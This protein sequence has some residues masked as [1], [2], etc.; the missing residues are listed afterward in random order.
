MAIDNV[1]IEDYPPLTNGPGG[2]TA[3]LKLWLKAND[4]LAY[5]NGQSVS[6]WSDKGNGADAT[7][8]TSGQEPTYRDDKNYNVNFNPVVDFDNNYSSVSLD[9]DYSFDNT[10]TQFLEGTGGMY[11]QDIFL[12]LIP[13]TT[14]NSSF[15]SMDVF[16]GDELPG[17]N[18]TDATGIGLGAYSVR[19]SSEIICY[20]VGTTSSGNGY[21]VAEIGTGNTYN[22]AGII[23]SRNNLTASQQELYYNAL[24]IET[25]QNDIPDFSNVNNSRYWIGR[26]EGW[27][28]STDARIAEIITYSARKGDASLTDERNKI[29][30][31]LGIKYG[32]TLGSNGTSQDY[33]DSTGA[34]IWDQ[35]DN[36]G[37][38]YDI[39]G[40][41]RDDASELIQK[42]SKSVNSDFDG[43][44]QIRG[45]VS[46]GLTN[47]Y[48]T[49]NEN[50]ANNPITLN[51]REFLTWGNNNGNLDNAPNVVN[52][53][54]STGIT[55]LSTPVNFTGMERVWRVTE[56]N[57]NIPMVK[58][59]IPQSAIRNISPP[60]SYLMFISDTNIFD[61]TADY[62]VMT[63]NGAN[64]ET[65]YDFDGTKYITFGYAPEIAVERSVY[66]DGVN[67]YIDMEDVLD[68]NDSDFTISAWI[69]R[70]ASS[71]NTSILS[72]RDITY[73][74]GYDFKVTSAGLIEFSWKNGGSQ[75]V[76]SDFVVPQ[77]EWHQVAVIFN[78]GTANLYIDGILDKTAGSLNNPLDTDHSFFIAAAGKTAPTALFEGNI[79]E[80]RIWDVALTVD[81]LHYVMNQE[82]EKNTTFVNGSVLHKNLTKNEVAT[83]PWSNLAGYYPMSIYTYTNTND[84]SDNDNQGALRNLDTVDYQT[85]PLPYQSE[86]NGSWDTDATWL[87]NS[88]QYLP[89][90]TVNGT[91]V[92][93]NIVETFHNINSTR[94]I[95]VLGLKNQSNEISVK[96]DNKLEIT[97]YLKLDGIIDLEN[98]SQLIQSSNCELDVDSSGYIERDQ[99]GEGN[100]YRYNDWSSPVILQGTGNISSNGVGPN[101][102]TPF[103][104][105]D[106][107]RDGTDPSNPAE[108][109]FV[110]GYN[111]A[112]GPPIQ[113]ANY[114]LYKYANLTGLYS[115]WNQI[116]S[117]GDL[118]AGEGFLM[119]GTGEPAASDQ[120]YVFKGKPNNG[121][122]ILNVSANNEYLVGNPYPSA[123]DA[124]QFI[125][126]NASSITGDLFFWEH[127]GGD[128][129][130]LIE[131]QAGYATYNL[132]GG[133]TAAS[134]HSDV[135]QTAPV[136]PKMPERYIPVA[137]GFFVVGNGSGGNIEFNNSQRTFVT[138]ASTNSIFMKAEQAS[139]KE[140]TKN[141]NNSDTRLK[142]RIGFEGLNIDHRQLLLTFDE[143]ATD[144]ID[145]GYDAEIYEIFEDDMYWLLNN[146]KYIIQA[147][148][149]FSLDKEISLGIQTLEGGNISINLDQL[150][151]APEDLEIY[152][153][154]K[155]IGETY[156]INKNTFEINLEAGEY[157]NRFVLTFQPRLKTL[158]EIK[159]VEGINIFMNNSISELQ[160][161][162]TVDVTI[163]SITLFNYLGQVISE[164][165]TNLEER[166]ISLPLNI[167]TGAYIINVKTNEGELN[168]KIVKK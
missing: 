165:N 75:T 140:I 150:E 73:T 46:I 156:K 3:D 122:I 93:W 40:I 30:S 43:T 49:N 16:C 67:D 168:K 107:L 15:G 131:Y 114:W 1:L 56:T 100:K 95:K 53:D 119:K 45:L 12:V 14:I 57:G 60:G 36:T 70:G 121:T 137:Q 42:Q 39:A 146:E 163:E 113:I 68:L 112:P 19:F 120:N 160:L 6:L 167:S 54:M 17:T 80:V 88:V 133:I 126:D 134:P 37:F 162:K 69:K 13:D 143:N 83:L 20:A 87:N 84:E 59:S 26:S 34:I 25:T 136:S 94:G 31:Y 161:K 159:L 130:N 158:N 8:N 142:I 22:N 125:L 33:V 149:K 89:N 58:V 62:R 106:V 139:T 51:D 2:I 81:Q 109:T 117:T 21:G 110:G 135:N 164:W 23:N 132:S 127:Y 64:L 7:V 141:K 115:E 63:T 77:N 48:N 152:I 101:T 147:T 99:Q 76:T 82:L 104:I 4:G 102:G 86:N 97:H 90:T 27:E 91:V 29:Q 128:S 166:L 123:L 153:K 118:Y 32:I 124:D 96:P 148:N 41:G 24:D 44:G 52:V 92:D 144:A 55:G 151:N 85:A 74:E 78:S 61:P 98:E 9:G 5:T 138:E 108:I 18:Q 50:I 66:F 65:N 28:A 157:K 103:T 71:G 47:L 79:D 10:S 154:D 38:N 11:T 35:S 116:G 111:G 145:W 155:L 129:H 72:K 105:A